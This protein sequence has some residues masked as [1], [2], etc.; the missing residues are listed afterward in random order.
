VQS[1]SAQGATA[2]GAPKAA[3]DHGVGRRQAAGKTTARLDA[4]LVVSTKPGKLTSV[5][6]TGAE[7]AKLKGALTAEGTHWESARA[8]LPPATT[9]RVK[10]VA[11]DAAGVRTSKTFSF[12]TLK[13]KRVMKARVAPL[14]G[15]LVGVGHPVVVYFT[16]RVTDRAAVEQRLKVTADPAVEGAWHWFS[17]TEVHYRPPSYWAPGT[18]VTLNADIAG[19]NAGLGTWGVTSRKISFR[20]GDSR[21][22]KVSAADHT[23]KVFVNG[24]LKRTIPVS[25]GR[26]EFPTSSGVH[27]V[28][29]KSEEYWMDSATIG[30]PRKSKG[31]Y[32]KKVLWNV[33]ISNS[34]EFVHSAPWSLGDQAAATSPTAASTPARRRQVV[35]RAVAARRRGRGGRHAPTD[36][37]GQ[38]LRRLEHG[39]GAL[40]VRFRAVGTEPVSAPLCPEPAAYN[41]PKPRDRSA[42]PARSMR[43]SVTGGR[44]PRFF[45]RSGTGGA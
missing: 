5:V 21:V 41:V 22:S 18:E 12:K 16:E 36:P 25:T 29:S 4:K 37:A 17:D 6:V 13:P 2:S 45:R 14:D 39:L 38:R 32:Y 33:R 40:A 31:G 15:D 27:V 35:L 3:E 20:I 44:P 10:A 26:Q 9:F 8:A 43:W 24:Q 42:Q 1:G 30:I 34:G 19:V 11:V 28:M 23:M 7:G